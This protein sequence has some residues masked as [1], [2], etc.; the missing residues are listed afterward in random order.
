[1]LAAAGYFGACL[2]ATAWWLR[3]G[4]MLA[5]AALLCMTTAVFGGV[6]W[7]LL[8]HQWQ[9]DRGM[10]VMV[11]R[12]D[13]VPLRT[14]NGMH[15]P[16]HADLPLLRRGMEARRRTIRGDWR[17]IEFA[18]GVVGWIHKNDVYAVDSRAIR[19]MP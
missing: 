9:R 7:R 2:T 10:P 11:I 3:R 19:A 15:Y 17:Q 13:E 18:S 6:S 1:L 5:F 8:D 4:K 14:G 12:F 16:A